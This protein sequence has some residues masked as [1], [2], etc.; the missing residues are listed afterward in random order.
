MVD[1]HSHILPGVDD[2][3]ENIEESVKLLNML[4]EQGVTDVFATPHFYPHI[5][6]AEDFL[7]GRE[8]ARKELMDS[9]KGMDLPK[10]H[11]GCELFY[12]DDMGKIGD[13]RPFTLE[14]S[15][16]ILLELNMSRV[17]DKVVAT[18]ENLCEMGFVPV[19]AHIERYLGFSGIKR[20]LK[21]IEQERC[22]AQVNASAIADGGITARRIY[23]LIKKGYIYLVGSD[24]HSV[25]ERPPQIEKAYNLI[26]LNCG[27]EYKTKLME[28]S[29]RLCCRILGES[30][31]E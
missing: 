27:E 22:F 24:T 3:A 14:G 11:I 8:E 7:S 12:F 1:F 6:S 5:Q 17:T 23:K 9:I 13:I 28:N 25:A 21:F 4:K 31:E 26:A 29:R 18:V 2:G 19:F 30:Y 20:I 16:Y 10:I 15:R